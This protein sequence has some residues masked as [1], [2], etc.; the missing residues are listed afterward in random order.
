MFKITAKEQL[1]I[2]HLRSIYAFDDT[3][4][5]RTAIEILSEKLKKE[6]TRKVRK[7][8]K[9]KEVRKALLN[10]KIEYGQAK[11]GNKKEQ[12]KNISDKIKKWNDTIKR[13][14]K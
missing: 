5:Y 10:K 6:M 2:L 13:I 8:A 1:Y 9:I 4:K 7:R 3:Q 14:G 11:I 12:S